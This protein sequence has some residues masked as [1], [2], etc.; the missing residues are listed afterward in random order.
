MNGRSARRMPGGA[1]QNCS[2]FATTPE[3]YTEACVRIDAA[4]TLTGYL[5][6]GLVDDRDAALLGIAGHLVV[7]D[8]LLRVAA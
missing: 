1:S 7:A 2:S 8:R 6:L 3:S 4:Q 5:L